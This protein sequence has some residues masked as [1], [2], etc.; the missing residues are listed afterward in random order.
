MK[1]KK[2]YHIIAIFIFVFSTIYFLGCYTTFKHPKLAK[3]AEPDS[4]GFYHNGD[5][6]FNDDCSSCHAQVTPY[7]EHSTDMYNDPLYNENYEWNYYFVT[8]WWYDEYYYYETQP[9]RNNDNLDPTQRR[10]FDRRETTEAPRAGA[11]IPDPS[12]PSLSKT[13]NDN[14][15]TNSTNQ[16]R[17]ERRESVSTNKD[18]LKKPAAPASTGNSVEQKKEEKKKKEN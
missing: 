12:R 14:P 15:P 16:Q 7:A 18:N 11:G 8:P 1:Q 13:R 17:H 5:V 2:F 9:V 3:M 10:D 6:T 4:T